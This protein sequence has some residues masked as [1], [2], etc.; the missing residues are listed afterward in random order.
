MLIGLLLA[1][2]IAGPVLAQTITDVSDGT[3]LK[4]IIIFG[5]HSIRSSAIPADTLATF[6]TNTYPP[7][8]GVPVGYL[9][10]RGQEAA[11]LLGSYFREYLL[12][13]GLLTGSASTDLSR[14]YFRA[15]SI[16]RS[17]IT[18]SKIGE[19]L[20][21]GVTIPVHSYRIADPNTNT[22]AVT[23][24]VFDPVA[25]GFVTID[26][27]RALMVVQGKYGTAA[28]LASAYSAEL[29]L[30]RNVLA[31]AGSVDPTSQTTHPFTLTAY[32]PVTNAG[33]AINMGGLSTTTEATDPFVM[34]Y[35]DNFAPG[36]VGW[37]K[38]T[39]DTLSQETRLE[40]LK[41]NIAMRS[42]YI[43]QAQS[44][45]AASHVLRSMMQA[46]SNTNLRGAFGDRKSRIVVVTSSDYYVAGLAGLLGLHWSLQSY[47]PDF[48]APAG[49]LVFELRQS[50]RTKQY[51]VRVH[52]TA[53]TFD[54]LRNLTPLTS[55]VPPA[56][57][58]LT[59]PGGSTSTT[60]LDVPWP[61]F[62]RLMTEAI[63][64]QYVQPYGQD[65]PP[66]V[67]SNVPLD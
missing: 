61:T 45:N 30:V 53:Q 57:M 18:A 34:Q 28:A 26:S 47:Q 32:S 55:E 43:N 64:Q 8:T 23:D 27:D 24:P 58:Q 16:Q 56:T 20:I 40:I 52:Y 39:P 38:F 66:G 2:I 11:R 29:A 25:A 46:H 37:G 50:N 17:N 60:N 42:P 59:V 3:T 41:I 31:P 48:C 35:T 4:Q 1:L 44:S 22:P 5:R 51:F 63:G 9:T 10:P 36:D 21:P 15:N 6:S 49:A 67:I 62:K 7:F 12:S 54:Q 19:G 14:S 65:F 33:L 13:E